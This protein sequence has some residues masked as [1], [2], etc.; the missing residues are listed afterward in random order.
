MNTFTP[1][2]VVSSGSMT[3]T[4]NEGDVV[5]IQH[6]SADAINPGNHTNRTGDVILYD[7][8]GLWQETNL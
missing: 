8:N 1:V 3:S 6:V 7:P 5:F 2:V 4:I